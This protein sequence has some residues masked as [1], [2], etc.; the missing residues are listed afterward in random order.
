[1]END[2]K[3]AIEKMEEH[4]KKLEDAVYVFVASLTLLIKN[5]VGE[6]KKQEAARTLNQVAELAKKAFG[7]DFSP[8]LQ[9]YKK[10]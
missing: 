4:F 2:Y 8:N 7:K 5:L 1:M 9:E 10:K 3:Q 6:P